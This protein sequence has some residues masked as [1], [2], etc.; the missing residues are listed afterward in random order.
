MG[1]TCVGGF[2]IWLRVVRLP[3]RLLGFFES[4]GA[5]SFLLQ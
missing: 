1:T 3:A 5:L 4:V 2:A